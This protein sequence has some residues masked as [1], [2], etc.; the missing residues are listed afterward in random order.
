MHHHEDVN[1]AQANNDEDLDVNMKPMAAI[2]DV[3]RN[4]LASENEGDDAIS[5]LLRSAKTRFLFDSQ[6]KS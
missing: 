4:T 6:L 2:S 1:V 3:F 5:L